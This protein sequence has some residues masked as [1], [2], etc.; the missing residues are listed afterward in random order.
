M[1]DRSVALYAI[2]WRC[3]LTPEERAAAVLGEHSR[4]ARRM[5]GSIKWIQE[6]SSDA[7]WFRAH[8]SVINDC[9]LECSDQIMIM[10]RD[11]DAFTDQGLLPIQ[12][13]KVQKVRMYIDEVVLL[14]LQVLDARG[15][16]LRLEPVSRAQSSSRRAQPY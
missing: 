3:L 9:L 4:V 15:G 10:L 7:Y 14:S 13:D 2:M 12:S 16:D 8:S 1:D 11:C 5:I 6:K